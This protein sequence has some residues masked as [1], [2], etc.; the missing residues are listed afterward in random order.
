MPACLYVC[1]QYLE[2]LWKD[3]YSIQYWGVSLK[4]MNHFTSY[5]LHAIEVTPEFAHTDLKR[6]CVLHNTITKIWLVTT[7]F[8][9]MT[10][11][12]NNAEG[13]E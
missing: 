3:F 5:T 10:F 2:K 1:R 11:T 8:R 6:I 9:Y 13:P 4:F 7:V 12:Y